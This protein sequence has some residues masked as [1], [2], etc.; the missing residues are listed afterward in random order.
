MSATQ[1]LPR[2]EFLKN[3]GLAGLAFILGFS[4]VNEAGAMGL[5]NFSG[6][7]GPDPSEPFGLTAYLSIEK[8]GRITFFNPKPEMG[9]GT[10]QSVTALVAEELEVTLDQVRVITSSGQKG[11]ASQSAG[12]SSSIRGGYTNLR[13]VGAAAREMLRT[14]AS[15]QWNVPVTECFAAGNAT[16][17]HQPTGKSLG[18]GQ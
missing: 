10:Y 17:V 16:I 12:G 1:P 18:Y 14:A 4:A 5:A 3:T 7:P 6:L 2:R 15:K 8:S 9:Q 11:I 13:K